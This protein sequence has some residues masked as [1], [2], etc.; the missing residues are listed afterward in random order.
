ML[1][2]IRTSL[3]RRIRASVCDDTSVRAA[4]R[5]GCT[6]PDKDLDVLGH[7]RSPMPALRLHIESYELV[8]ISS[9]I[10]TSSQDSTR[11]RLRWRPA[12]PGA[13]AT[14]SGQASLR[15]AP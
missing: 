5:S 3:G 4:A 12:A 2:K 7:V 9:L 15:A 8:A 6:D 14:W 11:R 1:G 10:A 13:R